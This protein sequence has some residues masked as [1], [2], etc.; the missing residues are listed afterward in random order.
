MAFEKGAPIKATVSFRYDWL[1]LLCLVP[2]LTWLHVSGYRNVWNT[3][4]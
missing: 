4:R 2:R 1:G 3:E